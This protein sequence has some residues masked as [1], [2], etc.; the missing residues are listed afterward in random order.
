[1]ASLDPNFHDEAVSIQH[2]HDE[3]MAQLDR[4]DSA[5][6]QIVCYSEVFTDLATANQAIGSRAASSIWRFLGSISTP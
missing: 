2:E 5:L 6:E 4:L 1:M 3:L